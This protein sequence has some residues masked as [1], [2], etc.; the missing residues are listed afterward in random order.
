MKKNKLDKIKKILKIILILIWMLIVFHFS[1]EGG[2]KSE[3]T[4]RNF[5]QKV[6]NT[7][8]SSDKSK[9]EDMLKHADKIIRKLAHYTLYTVGG[10]IIINYF[11]T[12]DKSQKN[13]IIYSVILGGGYAISD[14]LH[15]LFV[16]GRSARI[17]DVGIDTLGII[18]GVAIYLLIIK[19]INKHKNKK[20]IN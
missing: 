4:S 15:Q 3:G 11:H 5:S 1:S 6:L 16:G 20:L 13:K 10:I 2:N 12:T 8:V 18:T 9:N 19:F 14:E 17:L 7:I